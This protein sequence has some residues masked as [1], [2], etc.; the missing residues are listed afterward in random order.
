MDNGAVS[1]ET[2]R[3]R[4]GSGNM[5]AWNGVTRGSRRGAQ[6][7]GRK[8]GLIQ[9]TGMKTSVV[10]DDTRETQQGLWDTVPGMLDS[11][12]F[13]DNSI[14][15][16]RMQAALE[17]VEMRNH[18]NFIVMRGE[19]SH[20]GLSDWHNT[21]S[22][23][24]FPPAGEADEVPSCLGLSNWREPIGSGPTWVCWNLPCSDRCR[25]LF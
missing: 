6:R 11:M 20:I 15:T 5:T 2:A 24:L 1:T 18:D 7:K 17:N 19:I 13:I 8:E 16:R 14:G 23:A 21:G 12:V 10:E 22:P 4:D 3:G 25:N 9:R